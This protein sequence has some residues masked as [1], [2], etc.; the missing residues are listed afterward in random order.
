MRT[1]TDLPDWV[2]FPPNRALAWELRAE[3]GLAPFK[4]AVAEQINYYQEEDV[5]WTNSCRLNL[6]YDMKKAGIEE[7][8]DEMME[9]CRK[10]TEERLKAQFLCPCSWFNLITFAAIDGR[11]EDAIERTME[12]LN[13]GDSY[14]LLA[15]DPV[16]QEWSDRQEYQEIIDRNN[17]Q[18]QRQQALYLAGVKARDE[19]EE[20][21]DQTTGQ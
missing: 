1:N 19:A 13:N 21:R 5:P 2:R 16:I 15:L 9:K 17:E 12:W 14:S 10:K 20:I 11:T 3:Q 4:S 8:V 18:V 6:L 7:G